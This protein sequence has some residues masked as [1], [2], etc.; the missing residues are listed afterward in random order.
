MSISAFWGCLPIANDV[1][2]ITRSI[3]EQS[4]ID[5]GAVRSSRVDNKRLRINMLIKAKI[6]K[7]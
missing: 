1:I 6:V 3:K 2:S 7:T 4:E 5:K